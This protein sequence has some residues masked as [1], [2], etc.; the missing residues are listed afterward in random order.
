MPGLV[1]RAGIYTVSNL[2]ARA[3]PFLLLP[4]LTRYLTPADYGIVAMFLFSAMVLEP[5][6][7]LNLPGALTVKFFDKGFDL[8]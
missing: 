5:F 2:A 8:P 4:V 1:Q 6:L 3:L 7:T